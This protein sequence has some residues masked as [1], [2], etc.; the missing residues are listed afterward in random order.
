MQSYRYSF[1]LLFLLCLIFTTFETMDLAAHGRGGQRAV[2]RRQHSAHHHRP[3]GNARRRHRRRQRRLDNLGYYGG[4]YGGF[5]TD[6]ND[7]TVGSNPA[8]QAY[9]FDYLRQLNTPTTYNR[10]Y[11]SARG[12][13]GSSGNWNETSDFRY[14]DT[15]SDEKEE[16][17][18]CDQQSISEKK[19]P[20]A[21]GVFFDH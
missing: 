13:G 5:D 18:D 3:A 4:W 16:R 1:W 21:R 6:Y 12:G 8:T 7:V 11:S 20:P 2:G 19:R 9:V 14:Y 10:P 17:K 15:Y